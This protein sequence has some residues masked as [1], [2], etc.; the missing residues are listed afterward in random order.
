MA[1]LS[2][3]YDCVFSSDLLWRMI[4]YTLHNYKASHQCGLSD[5]FLRYLLKGMS[6]DNLCTG[7]AFLQCAQVYVFSRSL[8]QRMSSGT[9]NMKTPP[10]VHKYVCAAS[11][12]P[13]Y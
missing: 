7:E 2:C 3:G 11:K 12:M 10:N 8:L 6:V 1:F 5:V 13:L 4:L 9:V